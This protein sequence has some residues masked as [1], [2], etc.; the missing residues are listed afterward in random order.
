MSNVIRASSHQ[1]NDT[2][3][4]TGP[5]SYPSGGFSL[6]TDLGRVDEAT[7]EAQDGD[8]E[9]VNSGTTGNNHIQTAVFSQGGNEAQAGTD[10]SS[11]NF[12][13]DA[14]RL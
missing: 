9:A 2:N 3:T 4:R 11:I 6:R 13:Y 7:V 10:L 5:S 14:Y 1:Q 12:T 8:W